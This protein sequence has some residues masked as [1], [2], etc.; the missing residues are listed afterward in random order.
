[1]KILLLTVL[2]FFQCGIGPVNAQVMFQDD[3]A[4]GNLG[5]TQNGFKW[6]SSVR[7][8]VVDFQGS[9]ALRM[10]YNGV[11]AGQDSFTEQ[12][13]TLGN[14]YADVWIK[15]DMYVPSNYVM[16]GNLNDK[17][18]LYL[19]TDDYSGKNGVGGGFQNW[20]KSGGSDLMFVEWSGGV[21]RTHLV[22][23]KRLPSAFDAHK[24]KWTKIVAHIKAGT[25]QGDGSGKLWRDGVLV[26]VKDKTTWGNRYP[27]QQ[28]Q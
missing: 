3:F 21:P 4:S 24:G 28:I 18:Y 9:K 10:R 13:F 8:K 6:Q 22:D 14:Y 1:M 19:W 16:R 11:P 7:S 26:Y 15:Y 12:R 20:G 17:S 5:K 2:A 23:G 25:G 27:E